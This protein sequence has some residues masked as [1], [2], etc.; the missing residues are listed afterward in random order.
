MVDNLFLT[1]FTR[2]YLCLL[3]VTYDYSCLPMFITVYSCSMFSHVYLC[4]LLLTKVHHYLLVFTCL[5]VLGNLC[6][7]KFT[8]VYLCLLVLDNMFCQVYRVSPCLVAFSC[9]PMFTHVHLCLPLFTHAGLHVYPSLL[10]FA[11][12]LPMFIL[13]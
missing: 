5:F 12:F 4:S 7:P 9:L 3:L 11:Y 2:V 13:L 10:G 8:R 6:L 1:I